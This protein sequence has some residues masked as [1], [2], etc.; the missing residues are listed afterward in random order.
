MPSQSK[1]LFC[2]RR[3][4]DTLEGLYTQGQQAVDGIPEGQFLALSDDAVVEHV[5]SKLQIQPLQIYEDAI[6]ARDQESRLDVSGWYRQRGIETAEPKWVPSLRI[7]AFVPYSG[8]EWL[9]DMRPSTWGASSPRATVRLRDGK[10]IGQLEIAIEFPTQTEPERF[11]KVLDE[12]L[13]DLRFY[14]GHQQKDIEAAMQSLPGRVREAVT[15]RR[16]RL[17]SHAAVRKVLNIPLRKRDG[18]PTLQPP[19][20]QRKLVRPLPPVPA[21]PPEYG[22]R[23]EDYEHILGVVRHEGRTFESTPATFAVHDEEELRDIIL[24]HLNGH[25]NGVA[26]AEA[27]RKC[28]K[29]DIRIEVENRAAFVAECKVWHGEKELLEAV[30]QLLGYLTWRDCRTAL[31]LF[32]KD[33]SGFAAIQAKVPT[34]LAK[35][36]NQAGSVS[37]AQAGEWRYRFRSADDPGRLITVHVF[38]FNLYVPR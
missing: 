29:T 5:V 4:S 15:R 3:L 25:Y 26:T 21:S 33:V 37:T 11:K 13:S 1:G 19:P 7:T 20:I 8:D 17:E 9:W 38:L 30:G 22:I 12:Q 31:V 18:A 2:E 16:K 35:H 27:F 28:G 34:I 10:G 14:I 24:A 23:D 32:N 36:S 6:E